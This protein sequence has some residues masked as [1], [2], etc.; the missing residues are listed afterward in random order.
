MPKRK[1]KT[2]KKPPL[3][4]S[5]RAKR[6]VVKHKSFFTFVGG[7]I[8]S[9]VIMAIVGKACNRI[10]P[11]KPIVVEKNTELI[12]VVH[13]FSPVPDST[14]ERF[15]RQS[16]E[17]VNAQIIPQEVSRIK[18][19][20]LDQANVNKVLASVDF[21]NAKGYA[22]KSA[23]TYFALEM[24]PIDGAYVDFAVN[25]FNQQILDDIYCLSI[26][27]CKILDGKRYLVLD[28]NYEKHV[29]RNIIRV[30]NIF[31]SKDHFEIAVGFFLKKD[32]KAQ[33][34]DFYRE[35]EHIHH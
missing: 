10:M 21:P 24:S 17:L 11:D 35:V 32:T 19:E 18:P 31:T 15:M 3:T 16:E 23:A 27:V 4:I 14:W 12:Q 33:Y 26:K 1:N 25:F 30:R 20:Q 7:A 8:A 22:D 34:P 9:A 13:T 5:Q 28:C 29:G 6:Y 2:Q